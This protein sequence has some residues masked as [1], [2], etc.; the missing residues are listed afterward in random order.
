[1]RIL[2]L[3]FAVL[4]AGS[5]LGQSAKHRLA[6][7]H[8]QEY[9]F[10]KAAEIYSDITSKNPEDVV[11]LRRLAVCEKNMGNYADAERMMSAVVALPGK[12]A[13]DYLLLANLQKL[14][15]HYRKASDSYRQYLEANP[16]QTWLAG[17][18]EDDEWA[19]KILR[20]SS[21]MHITNSVVN[22]AASDFGACLFEGKI[23]FSS[24]RSEGKG[25]STSYAWNDQSYLNLFEAQLGTD[26]SLTGAQVLDN[27]ANS[28]YHEG[29][30][31][32][33]AFN[34]TLYFTR[35]QFYK[36]QKSRSQEGTLKLAIYSARYENGELGKLKEFAH[37]D[38]DFS[39]G[40][41]A[42][43]A[44]GTTLIFAS[45]MPGG[46]GGTDLYY[47][48]QTEN[49]WSD[50]INLGGGINTPGNEMFPNLTADSVLTFASDG[51]PG[52]GGL[53]LFRKNL[54][55]STAVAKN[56]GYPINGAS[57]DF[58]LLMLSDERGLFTSNRSGGK[59]DDDLYA[60]KFSMPDSVEVSGRITDA[61]T[62]LPM[63]GVEII[64]SVDGK[65]TIVGIS[66]ADGSY[67]ANVPCGKTYDL[68]TRK[69]G[70]ETLTYTL[71]QPGNSA[72]IDTVDWELTP[73]DY[74]VSGTVT[75]GVAATL[76]AGARVL[77]RDGDGEIMAETVTD[78]KGNYSMPAD[79]GQ[80]YAVEVSKTGFTSQTALVNTKDLNTPAV[81]A[82]V[83]LFKLEVGAI[84]RL[85]NIY[86]DYNSSYIRDD[87]ALELD[88]VVAL[89]ISNPS[90][91]IEL[92]SHTD[93]RGTQD[94]NRW[95]SD[96]RAQNATEYIVSKGI[97][98]SRVIAKGYGEDKLLNRCKSGVECSDAEHQENRRTEF[99]VLAI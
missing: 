53:D 77:L 43:S 85:D 17:Y 50:P 71:D 87:A 16:D 68:S 62:G 15:K 39:T 34:K 45:N 84:V 44:Y 73:Y 75:E 10:Q 92:S 72:F 32:Y 37:N 29:S 55:D 54:A 11:A 66:N 20:D 83:N 89:M 22:T 69:D 42:I 12:E 63:E 95:L 7:K 58:G 59:G 67:V 60:F 6:D 52:L 8:F 25:R 91:K 33:D 2:T 31:A 40:H 30:V 80:V 49:G 79:G 9:A 4:I 90:L 36:G 46:H 74:T 76:V 21:S 98:A 3:I 81:V 88:K 96:R 94:Y 61:I 57:D 64:H 5:A 23:M 65:K 86:Y 41:P 56:V 70:Y 18:I 51:L 1:M 13:S 82:D 26:S 19:N 99:T 24:G 28:R 47:C 93:S 14:N 48:S 27:S 38:P 78:D 35:N 97:K